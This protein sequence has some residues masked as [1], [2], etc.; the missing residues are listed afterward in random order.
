MSTDSFW[1]PPC[2]PCAAVPDLYKIGCL[3]LASSRW[4]GRSRE[5][6]RDLL[7]PL[8]RR[9]KSRRARLIP[10]RASPRGAATNCLCQIA[11]I[12]SIFLKI[13]VENNCNNWKTSSIIRA[14]VSLS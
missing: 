14:T 6:S 3:L 8:R 11:M 10:V 9:N 2:G 7:G 4:F 1:I 13:A 12:F 5:V